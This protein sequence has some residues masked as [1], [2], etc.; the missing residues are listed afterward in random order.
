M[1]F[2]IVLFTFAISRNYDPEPTINLQLVVS[3]AQSPYR[4]L[5]MFHIFPFP[6]WPSFSEIWYCAE[7]H[8]CKQTTKQGVD[9]QQ[10]LCLNQ[11]TYLFAILAHC[12][13]CSK[14]VTNYKNLTS[15]L[16]RSELVF[17]AYI[18]NNK[19]PDSTYGIVM[20]LW[21]KK[22]A[23]S[24]CSYTHWL[25]EQSTTINDP[26]NT[27]RRVWCCVIVAVNVEVRTYYSP[28]FVVNMDG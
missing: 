27:S 26:L 11:T 2:A 7:N 23:E 1:R 3:P 18:R 25:I 15:S 21:K 13:H 10:Q 5:W 17:F 4:N 8:K 12:K 24:I 14:L 16:A 22:K 6:L 9:N 19:I 28:V 20:K